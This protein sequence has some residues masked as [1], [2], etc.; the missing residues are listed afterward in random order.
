MDVIMADDFLP[1][2]VEGRSVE[3]GKAATA[4]RV[5]VMDVEMEDDFP[6]PIPAI[7]VSTSPTGVTALKLMI[8]YQVTPPDE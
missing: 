5:D 7:I 1:P 6:Y 4:P 2:T 3:I 8:L